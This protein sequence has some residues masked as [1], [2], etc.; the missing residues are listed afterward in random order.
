MGKERAHVYFDDEEID[1]SDLS[2]NTIPQKKLTA[3]QQQ[4]IKRE[5]QKTGFVSREPRKMGRRRTSPYNAQFGGK[6]RDGMKQLF[7]EIGKC[8]DCQDTVTLELAILALIEKERLDD[9]K[10]KYEKLIYR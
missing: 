6:C 2:L 3:D 9:L 10:P 7:Q 8:L 5:A 4:L 1:L